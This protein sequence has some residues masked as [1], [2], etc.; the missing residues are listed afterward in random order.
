MG[1][2]GYLQRPDHAAKGSPRRDD[3]TRGDH[4]EAAIQ[5][6]AIVLRRRDEVP[7]TER[8]RAYAKR[9][10]KNMGIDPEKPHP[11]LSAARVRERMP[12]LSIDLSQ[13]LR[14]QREGRE[15]P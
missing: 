1:R 4:L 8:M 10:L 9:S 2:E 6:D 15:E 3:G 13:R 12:E 7:D 14:A 5:D 11:D